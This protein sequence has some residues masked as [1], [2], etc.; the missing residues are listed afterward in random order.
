MNA[1]RFVTPYESPR[2]KQQFISAGLA[3]ADIIQRYPKRI[4]AVLA[5]AL[6]GAGSGA[7]AVAN[8]SSTADLLPAAPL[9]L[10]TEAVPAAAL[11]QQG[12]LL[13]EHGLTL[14]RSEQV[15]ASDTPESLLTRLGVSDAMAADYLRQ[16]ERLGQALFSA[17][18][19]GRQVTVESDER[20]QLLALRTHWPDPDSDTHYQRLTLERSLD[21]E[22]GFVTAVESVPLVPT[23][24][25]AS[26]TIYSSLFAATDTAGVPDNVTLQFIE[27]YESSIN[28]RRD[29]RKGDQFAMVYEA[30]EVDGQ[31]VRTGRLLSAEMLNK[32]KSR[33]AIWF[34]PEGAEK[35][36]YFDP[37][38]ESLRQTY[39]IQPLPFTRVTS[40]FGMRTHP[41]SGFRKGHTGVDFAAPHGTTV[42]TVADGVV[43]FAG[44]QRGYGNVIYVKHPNGEDSTVYAHLSR[45]N[46]SKG[47]SVHQGEKI[48]EVG[49]T[50]VATGPHL[51]FEFR[52]RNVP[53][54]PVD[55]LAR[56]QKHDPVAE[57]VRMAFETQSG[58][59][60]LQLAA[61][62]ETA[63]QTFE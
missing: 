42:R 24:R 44:V 46:V 31:V 9:R 25:L 39:L 5:L 30:L 45:I 49:A 56:Q 22:S 62:R 60:Q 36:D 40:D 2:V 12:E 23:Q 47:Q 32:G 21:S 38:G 48:G 58:V 18:A 16:D 8:L 3:F 29:L 51:H 53:Q 34:H 1:V 43:E 4:T 55:A 61:A 27:I 41:V 63:N 13:Q 54:N 35:G 19:A 50:G 20:Q 59:M 7:F 10:V 37:D 52:V 33:Q 11:V 26:G 14:Y 57:Q 6:L 17:R 28:F 15:R